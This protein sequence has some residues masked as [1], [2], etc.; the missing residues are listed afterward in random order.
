MWSPADAG[1]TAPDCFATIVSLA[2]LVDFSSGMLQNEV[3][4]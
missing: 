2:M 3:C 4:M 1:E